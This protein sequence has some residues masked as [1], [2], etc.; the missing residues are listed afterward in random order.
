MKLSS[1]SINNNVFKSSIS[2]IGSLVQTSLPVLDSNYHLADGSI[3]SGEIFDYVSRCEELYPGVFTCSNQQ[4]ESSLQ[5]YHQCGKYVLDLENRTVRIPSLNGFLENTISV[6][7]CTELKQQGL[8]EVSGE[9]ALGW[10]SEVGGAGYLYMGSSGNGALSSA[11]NDS[12]QKFPYAGTETAWD[13]TQ[14]TSPAP[15]NLTF[16][17]SKSNSIYGRTINVQPQS[18]LVLIYIRVK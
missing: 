15:V 8:P 7:N 9:I 1:I 17:A 14:G 10:S 11:M 12:R 16:N 13:N 3:L 2:E 18:V 6:E 4:F 5:R